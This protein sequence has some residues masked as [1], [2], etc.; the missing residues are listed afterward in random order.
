M[1]QQHRL[2]YGCIPPPLYWNLVYYTTILHR[3]ITYLK[4]TSCSFNVV[5]VIKSPAGLILDLYFFC[6]LS[7]SLFEPATSLY[8]KFARLSSRCS[9]NSC[10]VMS[11]S[12]VPSVDRDDFPSHSIARI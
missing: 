2:K 7:I 10:R 4:F 6:I 11:L 9:K 3:N 1:F 5:F 12:L 8:S